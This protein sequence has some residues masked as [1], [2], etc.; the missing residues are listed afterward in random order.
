M[1]LSKILHGRGSRRK[2]I[3]RTVKR[4]GQLVTLPAGSNN[5]S[6][7]QGALR[8]VGGFSTLWSERPKGVVVDHKMGTSMPN[9]ARW[10]SSSRRKGK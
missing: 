7:I 9:S 1:R 3:E 4:N 8:G 6:Q 2:L 10:G 5:T